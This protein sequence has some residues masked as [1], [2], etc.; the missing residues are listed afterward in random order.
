LPAVR[1]EQLI[2]FKAK[3][4]LDL[5]SRRRAGEQVDH[6]SIKKHKNDVFRPIQVVEPERGMGVSNS[7]HGDLQLFHD[8]IKLDPVDPILFG[9]RNASFDA[10]LG[11][12][13]DQFGLD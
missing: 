1:A 10:L 2:A 13:K 6:R 4:W 11:V 7:I 8:A 12:L 5:S 9:I 3:A